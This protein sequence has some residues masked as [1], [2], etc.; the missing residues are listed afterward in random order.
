MRPSTHLS[1]C[2]SVYPSKCPYVLPPVCISV[3][4]PACAVGE[5][6]SFLE[7][8]SALRE[9]RVLDAVDSKLDGLL[10]AISH[11]DGAAVE[12]EA[13]AEG[14]SLL[15]SVATARC[16]AASISPYPRLLVVIVCD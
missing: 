3:L 13:L 11:D 10:S 8:E 2:L 5:A 12:A 6:A 4:V 16:V 9:D 1:I 7:R 14:R 15:G